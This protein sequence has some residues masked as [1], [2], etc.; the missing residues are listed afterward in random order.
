MKAF[1]CVEYCVK[2]LRSVILVT[3]AI[4]RCLT[5]RGLKSHCYDFR[6]WKG[7]E[8][9]IWANKWIICTANAAI[10]LRANV[11]L[12]WW[13]HSVPVRHDEGSSCRN[14]IRYSNITQ[15]PAHLLAG[16]RL[17]SVQHH[18]GHR[19]NRR[20]TVH[21]FQHGTAGQKQVRHRKYKVF[22]VNQVVGCTTTAILAP[23]VLNWCIT[24][25]SQNVLQIGSNRMLKC[26]NVPRLR[27]LTAF[28][29]LR[30]HRASICV[31]LS[32]I[33]W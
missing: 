10:G 2:L 32:V 19:S 4:N 24:V 21:W 23:V 28:Q 31:L 13:W 3:T 9:L 29:S 7:L 26:K 8:Q 6:N 11:M 33:N 22:R 5:G 14:W 15:L 30:L 18:S 16:H 27:L 25:R 12:A 17:R 20:T 1:L